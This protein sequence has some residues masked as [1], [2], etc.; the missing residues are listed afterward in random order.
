L[1]AFVAYYRVN[2]HR[3]I[4]LIDTVAILAGSKAVVTCDDIKLGIINV[5]PLQCGISEIVTW[6]K[7]HGYPKAEIVE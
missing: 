5:W 3:S 6:L 1:E 7:T 4:S 2:L